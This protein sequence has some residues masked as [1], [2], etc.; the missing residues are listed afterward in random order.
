MAAAMRWFRLVLAG[1]V[2]TGVMVMTSPALAASANS[3]SIYSFVL[4]PAN[5]AVSPGGGTMA[6][7]GD[8]ISV[9]GSGL[10]DPA[11][12]TVTAKGRFVHFNAAGAVVCTGTWRASG[13]TSFVAFG[14]NDQGEAG[15]VLSIVVTHFCTTT[16]MTMT[17]IP[18]TVTSLV[19]APAGSSYVE[20]T[21]VCDFTVPTGGTVTIQPEQ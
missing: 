21:T 12:K 16:G 9:S 11:A 5:T 20:G 2:A 8:V 7:Q 19:D 3:G 13:F 15:G 18:M 4:A 6:S 10:F 1:A 17:G 14:V